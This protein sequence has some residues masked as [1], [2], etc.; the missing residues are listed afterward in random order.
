MRDNGR[1][2]VYEAEFRL[3]HIY[4]TI[5][6][7]GNPEVELDGIR[8][9]MPPEAKFAS[10]ESI[11]DY[12][13]K[14]IGMVHQVRPVRVRQRR[15]NRS[16]HYSAGVIAIP[17]DRCGWALREIVV[18]HE[19]SHH[20]AYGAGHGPEFIYTFTDLLSRVMG[21]ETGLAYQILCRHEGV[22]ASA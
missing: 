1:Q 5:A 9:T 6:E 10:V 3:R 18:L 2:K 22:L 20:I 4:D 12:R 7:T 11:Q 14:V 17:D 19:L 8:L 16:A 21:A 15:G 13:D